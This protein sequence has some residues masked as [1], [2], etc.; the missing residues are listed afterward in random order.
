MINH[1]R[2]LLLNRHHTSAGLE[3][4]APGAEFVDYEFQPL[5]LP[6]LFADIR[7]VLMPDGFTPYQENCILAYV[8][9]LLHTPDLEPFMLAFDAR[10]TYK[11]GADY[12]A[13]LRRAP[14]STAI[15]ASDDCNVTL[16]ADYSAT[17]KWT[18]PGDVMR[19]TVRH[20]RG[21]GQ[22]V[23]IRYNG[24]EASEHQITFIGD[25]S[26]K[27]TLVGGQ[28][29]VGFKSPDRQ[30]SGDFKYDIVLSA[31][32]EL[33]LCAILDRFAGL[34]ARHQASVVVFDSWVPYTN[35]LN[36]LARIWTYSEEPILK[37][38][39]FL[40]GYAY[41]CERM[42]LGEPVSALL[43]DSSLRRVL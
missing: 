5:A 37:V 34:D 39:A 3:S 43:R 9:R 11:L 27:L 23:Q 8:M 7:S 10:T 40:L 1:V 15:S 17:E 12:I 25:N 28:L 2:T 24:G 31:P 4:G 18:G 36:A 22:S 16:E 30:L 13:T 35:N 32:V 20:T 19:W 42:R 29:T 38:G 33:N 21:M 26:S 6:Q 14:L 41:Q